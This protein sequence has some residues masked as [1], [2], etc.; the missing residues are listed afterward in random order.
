M[1]HKSDKSRQSDRGVSHLC[2]VKTHKG[3][4]LGSSWD[5]REMSWEEVRGVG[6]GGWGEKVEEGGRV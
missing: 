1:N 4:I 6:G 2:N 5:D 3:F